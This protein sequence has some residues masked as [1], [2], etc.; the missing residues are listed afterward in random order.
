M[1]NFLFYLF[2]FL[3][4]GG[5]L[6][7]VVNLHALKERWGHTGRASIYLKDGAPTAQVDAIVGAL[8]ATPDVRAV[9]YMNSAEARASALGTAG[10]G[11]TT[12]QAHGMKHIASVTPPSNRIAA[13]K[14]HLPRPGAARSRSGSDSSA[15]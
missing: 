4:L 15:L 1:A 9:R 14:F 3:T 12:L 6:L 2:T 5:A 13:D 7:V 11:D 8:R 10:G